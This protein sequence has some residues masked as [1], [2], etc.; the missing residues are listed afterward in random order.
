MHTFCVLEW[1]VRLVDERVGFKWL[2]RCFVLCILY[3]NCG[4]DEIVVGNEI[5]RAWFMLK[6]H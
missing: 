2:A 3:K 5:S 6:G 1:V 4:R